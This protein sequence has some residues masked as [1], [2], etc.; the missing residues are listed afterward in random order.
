MHN[1][2]EQFKQLLADPPL[3]VGTVAAMGSGAVTVQ[4]PG[5]GTVKARG[6]ASLGA[7]VFVCDGVIEAIAPNL[8]LEIIEI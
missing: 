4:L 7:R 3:Q 8:T 6:N 2:Y 1:V 5:G